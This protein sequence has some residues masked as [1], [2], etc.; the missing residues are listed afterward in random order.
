MNSPLVPQALVTQVMA[1]TK[2][3]N[4]LPQEGDDYDYYVSFPGFQAFTAKM[5]LRVDRIINK[6]IRHQ[7]LPCYWGM[8]EEGGALESSQL[9]EK[10]ETLIEANDVLLERA[11]SL[12]VLLAI[13]WASWKKKL[14]TV[15]HL[16][17]CS[18]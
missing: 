14:Y 16:S 17:N 15:D 7:Q 10:F 6:I 1:A 12:I 9:E 2:S 4:K 11:V 8:E 13:G 5:G 18:E 3:S